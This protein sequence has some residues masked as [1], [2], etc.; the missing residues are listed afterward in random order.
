MLVPCHHGN[1][2]ANLPLGA[3][4][5]E[6][7]TSLDN[8]SPTACTSR[9]ALLQDVRHYVG[10]AGMAYWLNWKS[11]VTVPDLHSMYAIH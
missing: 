9:E 1:H 2:C 8:M 11:L 4:A 6:G 7:P 3:P 5:E 10:S